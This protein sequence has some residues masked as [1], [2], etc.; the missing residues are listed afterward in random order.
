MSFRTLQAGNITLRNIHIN[1]IRSRLIHYIYKYIYNYS[2]VLFKTIKIE[3][4]S[5]YLH[6]FSLF[7]NYRDENSSGLYL[8]IINVIFSNK[9]HFNS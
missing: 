8:N 4:T 1:N 3:I 6:I 2:N 9:L 7:K 5:V